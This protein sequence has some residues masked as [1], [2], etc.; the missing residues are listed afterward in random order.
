MDSSG[1]VYLLNRL[2]IEG[3]KYNKTIALPSYIKD[4]VS[5]RIWCAWAEAI[6]GE[7]RF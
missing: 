4:V 6:L 7:A 2:M 3:N 5:V 1:N